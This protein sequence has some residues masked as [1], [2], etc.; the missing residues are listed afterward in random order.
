MKTLL[1]SLALLL[2]LSFGS[3]ASFVVAKG[4]SLTAGYGSTG[5]SGP[6]PSLTSS[7]YVTQMYLTSAYGT[8]TTNISQSGALL[9]TNTAMIDVLSALTNARTTGYVK[10]TVV[11]ML[12]VNDIATADSVANVTTNILT[13]CANIRALFPQTK[14]A[15]MTSMA[16]DLSSTFTN[17]LNQVNDFIRTTA[18]NDYPIDLR[19]DPRMQDFDNAT[20]YNADGVHL[21]DAGYAVMATI[22]RSNLVYFERVLDGENLYVTPSGAGGTSGTNWSNAFA[23]FGDV[24]WGSGVGQLSAGDTLWVAGGSS[25]YTTA[26]EL[27]GSGTAGFPIYIKRVRA[28]NTEP[29]AAAGWSSAYDDTVTIASGTALNIW[30][31]SEAT[32]GPGH[33]VVVDGQIT[34]GIKIRPVDTSLSSAISIGGQGYFGSTFRY[35]GIYGPSSNA[36]EGSKT[37]TNDVRGLRLYGYTSTSW[38]SGDVYPSDIVFEKMTFSGVVTAAALAYCQRI[39]MQSND[40]HTIE[41]V[42]GDPHGNIVYC[43]RVIDFTF[44]HNEVHDSM[45]AVGLFFT[46]FGNGNVQS[47]NV[48]IYGNLFRDTTQASDRCIEVRTQSTNEGPFYIYNNTFVNVKQGININSPLNT[49]APSFIRNNLFVNVAS[50]EINLYG[51]EPNLTTNNNYT[52]TSAGYTNFVSSGTT[53]ILSAPYA[54]QY[55]RDLRLAAGAAPINL[56]TNLGTTYQ[57]DKVGYIRGT[58]GAWD[59]GAYEYQEGTTPPASTNLARLFS[60]PRNLR[61]GGAR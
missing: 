25:Q 27:K 53:N 48:H 29:A 8:I 5:Y 41:S 15:W 2:S 59:V 56:G 50:G 35:L 38:D 28:T 45:F 49:N 16:A 3:A 44:R 43:S 11:L 33:Y 10:S 55:V 51:T 32:N 18:A 24:V 61:I 47:S 39:T 57:L 60:F 54:W 36:V 26:L 31:E 12:Q 4:D 22:I 14:I 7:N 1:A 52:A 23:G 17:R 40:W 42:V 19:A 6:G 30:V 13:S 9:T 58:D 34:D 20:Y 21:T 37:W 46:Y